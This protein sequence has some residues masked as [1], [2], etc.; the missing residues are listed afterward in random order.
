MPRDGGGQTPLWWAAEK[1]HVAVVKLLLEKGAPVEPNFFTVLQPIFQLIVFFLKQQES[2]IP[3][4]RSFKPSVFPNVLCSFAHMFELAMAD[5]KRRFQAMDVDGLHLAQS[6]A[7]AVLDR[8][9]TSDK[10][11]P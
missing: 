2:Y 10:G 4:L 11:M 3:L 7:I 1:G 8:L 9:E 5:M 6:E